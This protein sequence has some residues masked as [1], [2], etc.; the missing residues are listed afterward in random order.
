MAVSPDQ[1]KY[2]AH[3]LR[4]VG[5]PVG[6]GHTPGEMDQPFLTA[7]NKALPKIWDMVTNG[8][9]GPLKE[10]MDSDAFERQ[11]RKRI[12]PEKLEPLEAYANNKPYKSPDLGGGYT[13]FRG[14][15]EIF[16]SEKRNKYHGCDVVRRE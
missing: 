14:C 16:Y 13:C 11:F 1:V 8:E 10:P 6:P 9:E 5:Y 2:M 7:Y 3:V 15:A 4:T 12:T